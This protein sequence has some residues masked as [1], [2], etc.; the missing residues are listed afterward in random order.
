LGG[1]FLASALHSLGDI[2][3]Q[4]PVRAMDYLLSLLI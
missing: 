3:F 1:K 4:H 2:H